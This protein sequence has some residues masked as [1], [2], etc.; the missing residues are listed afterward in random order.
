[1]TRD[2]FTKDY[3]YIKVFPLKYEYHKCIRYKN[4]RNKLRNI[5]DLVKWLCILFRIIFRFVFTD[6][7]INILRSWVILKNKYKKKH[8]IMYFHFLIIDGS[9]V[10]VWLEYYC[11]HQ[12][13]CGHQLLSLKKSL[14]DLLRKI[15]VCLVLWWCFICFTK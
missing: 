5:N 6:V 15:G 11:Y 4:I 8:C 7:K 1:M 13:C 9:Y 12:N 2:I 3:F 14:C 10:C